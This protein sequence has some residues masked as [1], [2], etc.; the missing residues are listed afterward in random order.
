[1]WNVYDILGSSSVLCLHDQL[2]LCQRQ[3]REASDRVKE[4]KGRLEHAE[5]TRGDMKDDYDKVSKEVR[6][7]PS[8]FSA[9]VHVS[10]S[11]AETYCNVM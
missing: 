8:S 6:V 7:H 10:N 3:L 4:L 2:E 9:L 11:S 1:M 5:E